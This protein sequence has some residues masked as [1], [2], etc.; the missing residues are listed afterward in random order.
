[1]REDKKRIITLARKILPSTKR[2]CT[3]NNALNIMHLDEV[4]EEARYTLQKAV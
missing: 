3:R 2:H 4:A 1:M